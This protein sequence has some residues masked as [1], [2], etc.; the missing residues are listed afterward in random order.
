MSTEN[1]TAILLLGVTHFHNPA[2]D[3]ANVEMDDILSYKRQG[4]IEQ[5]IEKLY[6]FGPGKI[7]VEA[8]SKRQH[9]IDEEYEK[10]L[11]GKHRKK[12]NEIYQLAF[13]LAERLKHDRVYCVNEQSELDYGRL[14][15]F[16]KRNGLWSELKSLKKDAE[17]DAQALQQLLKQSSLPDFLKTINTEERI[18]ENHCIYTDGLIRI[19]TKHQY[20]GVDVVADWYKVNMKIY[21]NILAAVTGNDKRILVIY[22]QGHIRILKHLFE[23]NTMF[24]VQDVGKWLDEPKHSN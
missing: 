15:K 22:G 6:A 20:P 4:E 5:V 7:F 14:I 2:K 18:L 9:K 12:R 13:R 10:Y 8:N 1:K 24:S 23:D 21:A 19:A 16:A 11:K 17:K 3:V